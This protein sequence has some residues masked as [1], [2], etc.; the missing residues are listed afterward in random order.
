MVNCCTNPVLLLSILDFCWE[1]M[2]VADVGK[3]QAELKQIGATML[4]WNKLTPPRIKSRHKA[5]IQLHAYWLNAKGS[6]DS[7]IP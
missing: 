3:S 7:A 5:S 1:R 6:A 4:L 2:N